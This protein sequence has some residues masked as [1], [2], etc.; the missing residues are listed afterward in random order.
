MLHM[1]RFLSLLKMPPIII[2][3]IGV[4]L[5]GLGLLAAIIGVF[6]LPVITYWEQASTTVPS[7][8]LNQHTIMLD[9]NGKQFAEI[10]SDDRKEVSSLDDVAPIMR[11]AMVSAED[12]NF[13]HHGAIDVEATVRSALT[14]SGG[15]SGITQQLVK[16]LIYYSS[17]SGKSSSTEV[18]IARKL[19]ELKMAL[20]Y[21]KTHS[22]NQILLKYLNIVSMGSP[23]TYGVETAA[24]SIFNTTASKLTIGQAAALAGSV[25]NT[26]VYN[27]KNLSDSSTYNRV[28]ARQEYVLKRMLDDGYITKAQ[29]NAAVAEKITT[30]VQ[31]RHGTCASS[32]YPF[33]CQYVVDY[34]LSSSKMG[35]T[36]AERE[37]RVTEGGFTIRTALDPTMLTQLDNQIKSDWGVTNEKIQTSA[38][39]QPGT[40]YVLAIGSNRNWGTDTS[41]GQTEIVLAESQTQTGSTYK[42]MTLAAALNDGWTETQLNAVSSECPWK[43]AGF[44]YPSGGI[45]DSVSCALQ[46]G[47]LTYRQATAYSA[48]T[49]FVELESEIGVQK[50]IDFSK[51]V[52]L[53]VP[54]TITSR[55][56]SFTLGVTD[57]SAIDMSAAYA[58]FNA[59]GVYCPAT[60]IESITMTDGSTFQAA[61]DYD[62]ST[63][64]CRSVMSPKSASIVLKAQD[65]NINGTDI[66]GRFGEDA[67][68]SDHYSVGKSGTTTNYAN[69]IWVQ[70]VAQYTVFSNAF[71]PRGNFQYPME[72]YVW[73]GVTHGPYDEAVLQTTRDFIE[74]NLAGV[75]NTPVDMTDTSST[76]VKVASTTDTLTMP[77][78]VGMTPSAA[79][80]TLKSLG[81]TGRV[82]RETVAAGAAKTNSLYPSGIIM[83]QSVA[84]GKELVVGYDSPIILTVSSSD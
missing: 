40:G 21:E 43:K 18:T 59:K 61:A 29:Y 64:A 42:M 71:D 53:E 74:T 63:D 33:Y 5:A 48:N 49:W 73:R 10:W 6:I 12:K 54:S 8:T 1:R 39:V 3:M 28:K 60:P 77:N 56:A 50:V 11:K 52:G 84:A 17:S 38:V 20:Q 78:L 46:G 47:H 16:N 55:S 57:N 65:A 15:G 69:Q 27:L 79:L 37:A 58:T 82:L 76:W 19:R 68:M 32:T 70:T 26:S 22:K 31:D 14:G 83:K 67:A 62:P 24:E 51:S 36:T 75:A 81:L 30:N 80:K 66:S 2:A 23:T 35:D 41:K 25:N 4:I 72:S 44:D 34:L 13:Y 45:S 9:K 7:V